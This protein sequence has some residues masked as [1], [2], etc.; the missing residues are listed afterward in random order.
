M[1]S[2]FDESGRYVMN[3]AISK[4]ER[5]WQRGK[6]GTKIDIL[7]E[8]TINVLYHDTVILERRTDGN[9]ILNTGGYKTTTTKKRM[10]QASELYDLGFSVYQ[11]NHEWY[12]ENANG[13]VQHYKDA[14]EDKHFKLK[15]RKVN[16]A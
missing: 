1:D 11:R 8:G 16:N 6:V 2:S 10:N 7:N 4:K 14:D 5:D 12:V 13:N 9:V 3:N 15:R